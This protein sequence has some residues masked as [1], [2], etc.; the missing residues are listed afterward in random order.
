MAIFN[1]YVSLP[2]GTPYGTPPVIRHPEQH[3]GHQRL[4][5]HLRVV[6]PEQEQVADGDRLPL[7]P[8]WGWKLWE[9]LGKLWGQ[10]WN[11]VI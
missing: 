6:L 7:E 3:H 11:M 1:S 5:L 4:H 10:I 2:A 8:D 9:N